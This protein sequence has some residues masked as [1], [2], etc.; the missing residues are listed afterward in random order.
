MSSIPKTFCHYAKS[1]TNTSA[2]IMVYLLACLAGSDIYANPSTAFFYGKPMPVDLLSHFEQVVVEPENIDNIDPLTAK[3]IQVFAYLSVGEINPSRT[4]HAEIPKHWLLGK[5]TDWG[6]SI[7]DLSK[8]EWRDHLI[9]KQIAPLW[10]RGY[11]GFFLDT[12][13][14]YQLIIKDPRHRLVQQQALIDLIRTIHRRFPGIQ[15]ILNRGFDLLPHIGKYAVAVAAESLFQRWNA[16]SNSYSEVPESDRAWLLKKLN[17]AHDQYG[18]QVIVIDYVP[19]KQKTLARD[20]ANRIAALGFTPWVSNPPMDMLGIGSVEVFPRRIL[21][22]YDGRDQSDGLQNSEVHKLLAMP[23][24]YLGYT[25]EY[26]DVRKGLPSYCLAGRY[27]GIVTWFNSDEWPQSESYKS[28]LI[29]QLDDGMKVG[30]FGR[31]GFKADDMFLQSLGLRTIQGKLKK[32]LKIAH[33]DDLI[34]YEAKPHIK[35]RELTPWEG[36]DPALKQHLSLADQ[37]GR[38]LA[39]VLTGKWGGAAL[40]PYVIETGFQ[41]R[42]RWLIDPFKFLTQ[43]LDLPPMPV[44]DVTTEKGKRLLLIQIDGDGA[45]SVAE[46]PGS[47]LAMEVIRDQILQVYPWPT[48]VSVIEGEIGSK[49]AFPGKAAQLEKVARDIFTLK[50]VEIASHSYSHPSAWV[51]KANVDTGGDDYRLAI[52]DY[53]FDLNREIVG[54]VDYVNRQLAPGHKQVRVFLW[55]GDALAADDALALTKT[56]GLENINGG[57]GASVTRS[58]STITRVPP[59]GYPSNENFQVYAPIAS[60]HVYT[61]WWRGPFSGMRRAIETFQLTDSPLRLKPIH[62]HYHFYSGS[63]TAA[64]K[65]L[66]EVYDWTAKQET[67]PIL[68]S[69]YIRKVK[70][71]QNV[72]I[73][74]H[75]DGAWDIRG[76]GDLR[77]LRLASAAGNPE[78][79]RSKGVMAIHE[80]PQGRYIS[81]SPAIDGQ[82]LLYMASSLFSSP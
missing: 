55:S 8:K 60:D 19:P 18:L 4:W 65:A 39:A 41:G 7:V 79:Q 42:Q 30:V 15:L 74:R 32:P 27:A 13:D 70:A 37:K 5:N 2:R 46:M 10:Q 38:R 67:W 66:K 82:V 59:L 17:E 72:T 3:G 57:G 80:L 76:L 77:T 24:E 29:R 16:V 62:I 48:T 31:L 63:K 1:A 64:I 58:E 44:P 23:L 78:L 51:E 53:Q 21:A 75:Q 54:S 45:A 22:L 9:N 43:A 69:E 11:R 28:W 71:F 56:L 36:V 52:A 34:G 50:H 6:S 33:S 68:M 40:H 81:L 47:P 20:V 61:G 14:S 25:L 12:L 49:G 26:A 73:A 35:L